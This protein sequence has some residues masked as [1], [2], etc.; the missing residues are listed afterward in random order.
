MGA[1]SISCVPASELVSVH[2]ALTASKP[3][4]PLGA[5]SLYLTWRSLTN[6]AIKPCLVHA[7]HCMIAR[8][9]D[10]SKA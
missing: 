9:S 10:L 3:L 8:A 4:L 5:R 6:T 2:V 7:T 1:V